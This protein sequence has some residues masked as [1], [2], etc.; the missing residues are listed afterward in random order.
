MSKNSLEKKIAS[1]KRIESRA[2]VATLCGEAAADAPSAREVISAEEGEDAK[3]ERGFVEK[4]SRRA[5]RSA[6]T[7]N[8]RGAGTESEG[9]IGNGLG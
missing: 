4:K 2:D 1:R 9:G 6:P 3:P 5:F 8:G 7:A